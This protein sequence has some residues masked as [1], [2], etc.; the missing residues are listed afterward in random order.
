MNQDLAAAQPGM[1]LH[2]GRH[3]LLLTSKLVQEGDFDRWDFTAYS[4]DGEL[5]RRSIYSAAQQITTERPGVF[6]PSAL[7]R[8][9]ADAR[10]QALK[11]QAQ[12]E[13]L[14]ALADELTARQ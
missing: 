1:Y 14:E 6:R 13:S 11:L 2:D 8:K 10:D 3:W 5:G 7:R 9:A 12:S 4:S